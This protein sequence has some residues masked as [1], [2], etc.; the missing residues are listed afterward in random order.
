MTEIAPVSRASRRFYRVVRTVFTSFFRVWL[1]MSVSGREHVP[2]TGGF[3]LA[4]G[5]HRSIIDTGVVGA[6]TPRMLRY[7]GA[8]KYFDVPGLGWFLRSVGGFPVERAVTDRAAL[9][10][11]EQVLADGE[12]LV[13]FPEATRF[14]GPE[15]QPLKEGAAFLA[16]RAGVPIIPV[17][18]GGAEAA[19]P[20]GARMI[21]PKKM[22]LVIGAPIMPPEREPGERVK[23]SAIRTM[24]A[25]LQAELQSLFDQAEA[26]TR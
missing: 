24:T 23:R 6:T 22:A 9:R 13:I 18:I 12:P 26:L 21:R 1:R 16:C 3:V 2:T 7:M 10:L 5:G 25:E 11:A 8:E 15:V 20:K 4:P 14:S 19:W 17:G